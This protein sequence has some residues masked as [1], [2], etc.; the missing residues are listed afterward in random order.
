MI[1]DELHTLQR[2]GNP[3]CFQF[4]Y[5]QWC[6]TYTIDCFC[7]KFL[8][9]DTH[10]QEI[11]NVSSNKKAAEGDVN[12]TEW[13]VQLCI[14]SN[15]IFGIKAFQLRYRLLHNDLANTSHVSLSLSLTFSL[16]IFNKKYPTFLN[17]STN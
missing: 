9:S 11:Y 1:I 10:T 5:W 8:Q 6:K 14:P 16:E 7:F 15:S 13:R 2:S 4:I 3:F 17:L 12:G